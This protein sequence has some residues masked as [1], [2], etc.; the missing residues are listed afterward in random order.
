MFKQCFW[1]SPKNSHCWGHAI[2]NTKQSLCFLCGK[3]VKNAEY[4]DFAPITPLPNTRWCIRRF[5]FYANFVYSA[6]NTRRFR[7]I[8]GDSAE[9]TGFSPNTRRFRRIITR[10]AEYTERLFCSF[11]HKCF[12]VLRNSVR[13]HRIV[14]LGDAGPYN[15]Q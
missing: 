9:Y 6:P 2:P 14:C 12:M 5:C 4:T 11:C 15:S 10:S 13:M 3:Y 8:H 7:R 1:K